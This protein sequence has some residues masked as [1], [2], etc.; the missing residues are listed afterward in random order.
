MPSQ[1]WSE[2]VWFGVDSHGPEHLGWELALWHLSQAYDSAIGR[3]MWDYLFVSTDEAI[4]EWWLRQDYVMDSDGNILT[5][6]EL[7]SPRGPDAEHGS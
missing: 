5:L 1:F 4:A 7:G 3:L 6:S 2:L